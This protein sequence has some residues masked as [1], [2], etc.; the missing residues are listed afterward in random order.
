MYLWDANILRAFGQGH[1]TLRW[2]LQRV[3][4]S[5]IALP[6]VVVAEVLR[7]R[8]DFALK[9]T[10]AEAPLAHR[11]LL[12]T[13]QMLSQ[14]QVVVFD[15]ACATVMERLQRRHRRRKRYADLMIAAIVAAGQHIL[16]TRN[17]ADFRDVLPRAQLANWIDDPPET[18]LP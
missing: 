8:C 11:R 9:A 16:V 7:G 5:E 17:Q 15:A 14:F 12:D 13:K 10:S 2:H 6:S 4:W 18:S 1:A 3:Q